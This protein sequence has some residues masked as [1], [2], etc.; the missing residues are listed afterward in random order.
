M[1]QAAT[2]HHII[3]NRN[4]R[5]ARAAQAARDIRDLLKGHVP[6]AVLHQAAREAIERQYP[7]AKPTANNLRAEILDRLEDITRAYANPPHHLPCGEDDAWYERLHA[8]KQETLELARALA[9]MTGLR[10]G[11]DRFLSPAEQE[12]AGLDTCPYCLGAMAYPL[13]KDRPRDP[14]RPL[15]ELPDPAREE[16]RGCLD[17]DV[18]FVAPRER[19]GEAAAA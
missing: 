10:F 8:Y 9:D 5:R 1:P 12:R 15:P 19:R 18:V 16:L 3:H 14:N 4:T 6:T 7:P 11:E 17:C 2:N 13:K